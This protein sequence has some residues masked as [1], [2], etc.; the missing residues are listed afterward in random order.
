MEAR[1]VVR[2][3]HASRPP[4]GRSQLLHPDTRLIRSTLG[5][6]THA[7]CTRQH[8]ISAL[9]NGLRVET[10]YRIPVARPVLHPFHLA[11]AVHDLAACRHFYGRVLGCEEGRSS[12]RWVDFDLWGH[13]LVIHQVPAA[14]GNEGRNPVDGAQVP[15]PHFGVVL[16]MDAWT[17]LRDNLVRAGV[18]FEIE[19]GI[20]FAGEVGEQATMFFYDPAGNALE[21]KAMRDPEA[22]FAKA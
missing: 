16:S 12:A 14:P 10:G 21:F 7:S 17:E 1:S 8:A 3:L 5:A 4:S 22:L 2:K 13:Q 9:H 20:R 19:P 11:I 6:G 18:R 15:V